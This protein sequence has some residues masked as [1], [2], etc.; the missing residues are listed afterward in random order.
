MPL[1]IAISTVQSLLLKQGNKSCNAKVTAPTVT[2]RLPFLCI[3]VL[4]P[5][6]CC[7]LDYEF[8]LTPSA[9]Y[10]VATVTGNMMLLP[11]CTHDLTAIVA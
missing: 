6:D 11:Q 5:V 2:M 10:C 4:P 7:H 3:I 1:V 8:V 9:S